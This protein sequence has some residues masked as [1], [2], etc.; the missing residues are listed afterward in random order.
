VSPVAAGV[1]NT[2][3]AVGTSLTGV[4]NQLGSAVPAAAPATSAATSAVSG[5]LDSVDQAV[6]AT[7]F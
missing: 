2:V 5:V 3:A 4:A 1:G 7:T 6:G